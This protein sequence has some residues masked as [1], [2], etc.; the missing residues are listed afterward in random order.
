MEEIPGFIFLGK[1]AEKLKAFTTTYLLLISAT[2][3]NILLNQAHD[4]YRDKNVELTLK[5]VVDLMLS[6]QG[7]LFITVWALIVGG[8]YVLV[9]MLIKALLYIA[10][11]ILISGGNLLFYSIYFILTKMLR[12][13]SK[14][15]FSFIREKELLNYILYLLCIY[16]YNNGR[17]VRNVHFERYKW[18]V[19]NILDPHGRIAHNVYIT[20]AILIST[21][22]V[23]YQ[24]KFFE[25]AP[26]IYYTVTFVSLFYITNAIIISWI[27]N[28]SDYFLDIVTNTIS[29]ADSLKISKRDP[30]V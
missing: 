14:K 7:T 17:I 25:L 21:W 4:F 20:T 27:V 22:V 1:S 28:K 26:L 10:R 11:G 13:K 6:P 3:T 2:L 9:P 5:D 12:L 18:Y 29:Y 15:K 30:E 19:I 23:I 24:Y 16:H 8:H